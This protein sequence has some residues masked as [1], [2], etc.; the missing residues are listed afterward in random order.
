MLVLKNGKRQLTNGMEL[1]NE[2]KIITLGEKETWGPLRLTPSNKWKWTKKFKKNI[3][4]ELENCSRQDYL[5]ETLSKEKN[6]WALAFGYSE[7]FL[8]CTRHEF[9]Q[10]DQ[11]T[12][13]LMNMHKALHFRDDVEILNTKRRLASIKESVDALIQRFEDNI[14]KHERGLI[15]AIKNDT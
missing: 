4:G 8:K 12:R 15:T 6:T 14:E 10:M 13:K 2:E 1:P 7:P 9:K 3:S 5:A 11:R